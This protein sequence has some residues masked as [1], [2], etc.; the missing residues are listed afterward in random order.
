MCAGCGELFD[1]TDRQKA[2]NLKMIDD[3]AAHVVQAG[4]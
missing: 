3:E 2:N 1:L 4:N